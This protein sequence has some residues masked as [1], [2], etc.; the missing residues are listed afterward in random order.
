[1]LGRKGD[2]WKKKGNPVVP[3]IKKAKG[4]PVQNRECRSFDAKRDTSASCKNTTGGG[5][6]KGG[7]KRVPGDRRGVA[8]GRKWSTS[9][10]SKTAASSNGGRTLKKRRQRCRKREGAQG[11]RRNY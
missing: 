9:A 10:S 1:V 7:N 6:S 11:Y 4:G 2:G 3:P 5:W 8:D